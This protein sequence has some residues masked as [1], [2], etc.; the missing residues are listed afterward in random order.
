ML[1]KGASLSCALRDLRFVYCVSIV[2]D[3]TAFIHQPLAVPVKNTL[4]LGALFSVRALI[5]E[6]SNATRR[7]NARTS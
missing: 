3:F 6:S 4:A 2:S 1:S 5:R 7:R